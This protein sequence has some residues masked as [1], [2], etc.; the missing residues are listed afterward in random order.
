[1]LIKNRNRKALIDGFSQVSQIRSVFRVG[2]LTTY[3]HRTATTNLSPL[4]TERNEEMLQ[5]CYICGKWQL[6]TNAPI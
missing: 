5:K 2:C 4:S 3:R 6:I 1:V